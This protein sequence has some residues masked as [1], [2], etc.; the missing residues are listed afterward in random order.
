MTRLKEKNLFRVLVDNG[1]S[2]VGKD[3]FEIKEIYDA[4]KS[5]Y[6]ELCDDNYLC[7]D[8]CRQGNNKPEWNHVVRK[9]L[10]R[11]KKTGEPVHFSGKRRFW[12]LNY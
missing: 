11:L 8:N 4:V 7:A 9:A 10:Y 2:F 5:E 1:F 6:G 3:R 12:D